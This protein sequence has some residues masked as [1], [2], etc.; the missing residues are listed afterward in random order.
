[1]ALVGKSLVGN[2]LPQRQHGVRRLDLNIPGR[3]E[4]YLRGLAEPE[5]NLGG[6]GTWIDV[7]IV[8]QFL[9]VAIKVQGNPAIEPAIANFG[10]EG[11]FANPRLESFPRR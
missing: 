3:R 6:V 1:M 11:N 2:G 8:F 5:G 4:L 10:I 7:E 9:T